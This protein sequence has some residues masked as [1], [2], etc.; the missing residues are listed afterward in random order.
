MSVVERRE[1]PVVEEIREETVDQDGNVAHIWQVDYVWMIP[2]MSDFSLCGVHKKDSG[3]VGRCSSF[4]PSGARHCPG[5]GMPLCS[6]CMC[7]AIEMGCW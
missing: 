1:T 2:R 3:H 5:C 4:I 7:K 6:I